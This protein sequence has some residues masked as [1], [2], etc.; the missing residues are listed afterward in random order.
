[1]SRGWSMSHPQRRMPR[2]TKLSKMNLKILRKLTRRKMCLLSWL[3]SLKMPISQRRTDKVT[4]RASMYMSERMMHVDE[5]EE[6]RQGCGREEDRQG[7]T[8]RPVSIVIRQALDKSCPQPATCPV[9][10]S[11]R[12]PATCRHHRGIRYE[13]FRWPSFR[14][15]KA[16]RHGSEA[17]SQPR[18]LNCRGKLAC[19]LH[20]QRS[21]HLS[22]IP[23]KLVR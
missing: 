5:V 9:P 7:S 15:D 13:V 10:A 14:D 1:M 3:K 17:P 2:P 22:S 20:C 19:V 12:Q 18:V 16:D 23:R 8:T 4:T 6:E 11:C 21:R